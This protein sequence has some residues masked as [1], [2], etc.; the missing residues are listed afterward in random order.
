MANLD[1]TEVYRYFEENET[2]GE[3]AQQLF[4]IDP[5]EIADLDLD[6]T[7]LLS[8]YKGEQV[9]A[10]SKSVIDTIASFYGL[11]PMVQEVVAPAYQD[12]L[13]ALNVTDYDK[14][15][16][17]M[18]IQAPTGQSPNVNP[19]SVTQKPKQMTPNV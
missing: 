12:I 19:A 18:Q 3:G 15:I 16:I 13:K 5:N 10:N 2:G 17:P 14:R 8:R 7:I 9:I 6:V 4:E 11:D 1:P